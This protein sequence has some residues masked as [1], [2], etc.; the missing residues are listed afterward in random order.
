MTVME[1]A[2]SWSWLCNLISW[3]KNF[4]QLDFVFRKKAEQKLEQKLI[5]SAAHSLTRPSKFS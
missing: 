3:N 5:P 2:C 1:Q 4:K